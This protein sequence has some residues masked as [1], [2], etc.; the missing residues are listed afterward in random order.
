MFKGFG[1]G[2]IMELRK[3][4]I[5]YSVV[6]ALI[7]SLVFR[8]AI[9]DGFRCLV[10]KPKNVVSVIRLEGE[11]LDSPGCPSWNNIRADVEKA[12]AHKGLKAVCLLINSG[13]GSG[14]QARIVFNGI[15]RLA[16]KKKVSVYSF[17]EDCACSAAYKIACVGDKIIACTDGSV[18]GG[19]GVI[20][21]GFGYVDIAKKLGIERRIIASHK[22]KNF[23]DPYSPVNEHDEK[24]YKNEI[25]D[26]AYKNFV[27]FVKRERGKR[28]KSDSAE[29]F[30]GRIW[31]AEH[32]LSL[33]LIDDVKDMQDFVNEHYGK[34]VAIKWPFVKKKS[35]MGMP[36]DAIT[37]LICSSFR[38]ELKKL[39]EQ[40][41]G[42]YN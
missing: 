29:L 6:A 25:M 12:F 11:I 36:L 31:C 22:S 5:I 38:L 32:A 27:S 40:E 13:G 20:Y 37:H 23:L 4:Y 15:R 21:R 2:V 33:G 34:D 24:W 26:V 16:K 7:L 39:L 18:V 30:S 1:L 35:F 41:V 28:L 9:V 19:I 3:K 8:C 42:C 14:V 10:D 17:V